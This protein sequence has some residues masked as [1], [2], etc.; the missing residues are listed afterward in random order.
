MLLFL[1]YLSKFLGQ[2]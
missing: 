2:L 1:R